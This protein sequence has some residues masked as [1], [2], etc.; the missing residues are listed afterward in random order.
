MQKLDKFKVGDD[1][2]VFLERFEDYCD[3]IGLPATVRASRLLSY[4]D[5]TTYKIIS[6]ELKKEV[7]QDTPDGRC[8]SHEEIQ[9][10]S[11]QWT[12]VIQFSQYQ[13]ATV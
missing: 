2:K 7:R 3:G 4:L 6:K 12:F 5:S 9:P 13:G 10:I 11:L 8:T 1:V